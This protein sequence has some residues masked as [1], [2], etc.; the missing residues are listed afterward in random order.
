MS[1]TFVSLLSV[2]TYIHTYIH[3]YMHTYIYTYTHE[4]RQNINYTPGKE[5][6]PTL[7]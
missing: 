2:R 3:K 6:V 5:R 7:L 4:R 1:K